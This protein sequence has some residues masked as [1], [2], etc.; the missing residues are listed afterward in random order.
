MNGKGI[1]KTNSWES[2][3]LSRLL[4]KGF[5]HGWWQWTGFRGHFTASQVRLDLGIP[6][7]T[8]KPNKLPSIAGKARTAGQ[9]GIMT[10][11][12][13]CILE[14]GFSGARNKAG[15]MDLALGQLQE[16][17][18]RFCSCQRKKIKMQTASGLYSYQ[19]DWT[20]YS[21]SWTSRGPAFTIA[22]IS[23]E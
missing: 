13:T 21:M 19:T 2:P 16:F 9:Q 23:K 22:S 14:P 10:S 12:P 15:C 4:P 8:E 18:G 5:S 7:T 17:T 6:S 1:K 20:V 3:F 11:F